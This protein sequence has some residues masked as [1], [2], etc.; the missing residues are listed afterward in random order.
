MSLDIKNYLCNVLLKFLIKIKSTWRR[1][2]KEQAPQLIYCTV[3]V[4]SEAATGSVYRKAILKNFAV[5][6]GNTCV[7]VYSENSCGIALD[8][9]LYQ[10]ETPTQVR[11]CEYCKIFNNVLKNICK[12]LLFNLVQYYM[13]LKV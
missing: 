10:K 6:K 13:N 3:V 1:E 9:Q 12:R 2:I 5:S 7:G 11:C 4:L 8:L